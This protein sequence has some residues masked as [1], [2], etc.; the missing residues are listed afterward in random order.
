MTRCNKDFKEKFGTMMD[1]ASDKKIF[2]SFVDDESTVAY[3]EG[4]EIAGVTYKSKEDEFNEEIA[5]LI[6]TA[7]ALGIKEE[8]VQLIIDV[9]FNDEENIARKLKIETLSKIIDEK[10]IELLKKERR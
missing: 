5:I 3:V 10:S 2:V 4:S 8:K 6:S 7:R 9:L 1:F